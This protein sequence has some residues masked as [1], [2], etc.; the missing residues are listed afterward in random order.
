M[1]GGC[2]SKVP[3]Y[4]AREKRCIIRTDMSFL[5]AVNAGLFAG[6]A[7]RRGGKRT[8]TAAYALA[9][10]LGLLI[11]LAFV[12]FGGKGLLRN[13]HHPWQGMVFWAVGAA[14]GAHCARARKPEITTLNLS[15]RET[16]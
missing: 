1:W 2:E 6:M 9:L 4:Y 5:S 11:A 16:Y 14:L 10:T 7:L 15:G 13:E 8:W 12:L 3:V